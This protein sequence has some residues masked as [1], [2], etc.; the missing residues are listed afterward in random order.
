MNFSNKSFKHNLVRW[1]IKKKF[2]DHGFIFCLKLL[3]IM[4]KHLFDVYFEQIKKYN[5]FLRTGPF[6][7]TN[8]L[9]WSM[10]RWLISKM[11]YQF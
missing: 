9:E 7:Y 4:K 3:L 10:K 1:E 2:G 8:F 5:I 6:Q 11:G